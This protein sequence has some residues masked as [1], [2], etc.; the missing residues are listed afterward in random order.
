MAPEDTHTPIYICMYVCKPLSP[1]PHA[2]NHW[3]LSNVKQ[4]ELLINFQKMETNYFFDIPDSSVSYVNFPATSSAAVVAATGNSTLNSLSHHRS[5]PAFTRSLHSVHRPAH[6]TKPRCNGNIKKK[7]T[8]PLPSNPTH[9]Y[10][11]DRSNFRELVQMLTG[12]AAVSTGPASQ[13]RCLHEVAPPPPDLNTLAPRVPTILPKKAA[14]MPLTTPAS[15][16]LLDASPSHHNLSNGI[17]GTSGAV[18]LGLG[19]STSPHGW[20]SVPLILSPGTLSSFE[21]SSVP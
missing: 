12:A 4:K 17:L 7:P 14:S 10:R 19:L 6:P 20:C 13:L 5:S 15:E 3:L 1:P 16:P 2:S 18:S 8:F 21:P 11:V 9:V